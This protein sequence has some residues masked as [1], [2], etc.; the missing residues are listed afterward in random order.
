VELRATNRHVNSLVN[1]PELKSGI[2]N[3]SATAGR[4][5]EL[6]ER[7]EKPIDRMLAD[8]PQASES[9]SRMVTRL[10]SV[11][12]DLPETSAQLRQTLQR[13][14]RLI[15]DQQREL[16]RTMENL[17]V[18]SENMKE[19]TENSKRLSFPDAI[20]R[21]TT[22]VQGHATMRLAARSTQHA[23]LVLALFCFGCVSLERSFPE[24]RYFVIE[25]QESQPANPG[26]GQTLSIPNFQ[27]SPRYAD[28]D[29]VYRTSQTEYES[30][31]YNQFLTPPAV[32]ITEETRKAL[33]SSSGFKFVVGASSPL[34][35][36]FVLEGAINALYGDFRKPG[37]A[38]GSIGN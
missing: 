2:A 25:V 10:D 24:K 38:C 29:F 37:R 21:A 4:A 15:A 7:A 33:A 5:R 6:F 13:V 16:A 34:T 19:I 36:N 35:A 3:A 28:R 32:M 9:L 27:I 31:F 20:W 17:R 22:V 30:D 11:T 26:N 14:N 12:K 23:A 1:S 8:L 18:V